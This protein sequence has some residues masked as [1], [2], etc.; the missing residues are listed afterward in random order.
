MPLWRAPICSGRAVTIGKC[1][2]GQVRDREWSI[3][4]RP[5][6]V[7]GSRWIS[8]SEPPEV[9]SGSGWRSSMLSESKR[10]YCRQET[11]SM[12]LIEVAS[13]EKLQRYRARL[14]ATWGKVTERGVIVTCSIGLGRRSISCLDFSGRR[15]A[16][17]KIR[18]PDRHTAVSVPYWSERIRGIGAG[19]LSGVRAGWS[20]TG[21]RRGARGSVSAARR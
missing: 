13:E 4:S 8:P 11:D 20:R 12:Y 10:I 3:G 6:G 5:G 7:S 17:T 21:R 18:L 1:R 2:D 14:R 16:S 15:S 19:G 9:I